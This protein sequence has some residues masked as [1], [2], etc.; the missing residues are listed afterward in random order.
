T[1]A[2]VAPGANMLSVGFD[3]ANLNAAPPHQNWAITIYTTTS[4]NPLATAY[5]NTGAVSTSTIGTA[6]GVLGWN[7]TPIAPFV[8]NGTD[9]IVIETCF[10]NGNWDYNYSTNWTTNLTGT[11]IKTRFTYQDGTQACPAS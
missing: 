4:A 8:W 1:A 11:D 2:G 9:N 3:I 6:T 5:M 10:A 7:Q